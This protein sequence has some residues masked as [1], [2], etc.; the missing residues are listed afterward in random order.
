[1]DELIP[2]NE[3]LDLANADLGIVSEAANDYLK[4][5]HDEYVRF[6]EV[7][8]V[9]ERFGYPV[10]EAIESLPIVKDLQ[11]IKHGQWSGQVLKDDGF[12]SKS[13]GYICSACKQFVPNKGNFCLNCGATMDLKEGE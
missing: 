10:E 3:I 12:G 11:N 4:I 6:A 13:V 9:G 1:M 2:I 7:R 8:K 5:H